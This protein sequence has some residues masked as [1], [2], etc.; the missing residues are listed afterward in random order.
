MR[1]TFAAFLMSVPLSAIGLMAI[2]G[3]PQMAPGSFFQRAQN[4]DVVRAPEF[5]QEDDAPRARLGRRR[6]AEASAP[7]F[8]A[9]SDRSSAAEFETPRR[10]AAASERTNPFS[11]IVG[12]PIGSRVLIVTPVQTSTT[13]TSAAIVADIIAQPGPAKAK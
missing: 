4:D 6:N 8:G 9:A 7:V 5:D 10:E 2:F 12:A 1:N 11:A 13:T 3:I